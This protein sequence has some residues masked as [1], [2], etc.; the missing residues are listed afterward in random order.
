M[1][2]KQKSEQAPSH[3]KL[4]AVIARNLRWYRHERGLSQTELARRAK[5]ALST[6]N[7]IENRVAQDLRLTTLSALTRALK[8]S[9]TQ[10][11]QDMEFPK[12]GRDRRDF[13]RAFSLLE[14]I[15]RGP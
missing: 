5:V 11:F 4:M 7:E 3:S 6:V 10:L 9:P 15:V 1:G 14:G 12:E 13:M 2:R 8:L